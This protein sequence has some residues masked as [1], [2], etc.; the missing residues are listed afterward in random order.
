MCGDACRA[1]QH[2]GA[3]L[4]L[5]AWPGRY[6]G[7][8]SAETAAKIAIALHAITNASEYGVLSQHGGQARVIEELTAALTAGTNEVLRTIDTIRLQAKTVTVGTSRS[9]EAI[10]NTPL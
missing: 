8:L 4:A 6:D 5:I 10:L 3:P 2:S 9:D 1:G 7:S